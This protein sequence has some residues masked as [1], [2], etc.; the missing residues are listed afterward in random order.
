MLAG[1]DG[2]GARRAD[3]GLD[4]PDALGGKDGVQGRGE[5]GVSVAYEE[6][7]WLGPLGECHAEVPGLLGYPGTGGVGGD[8][9][10]LDEARVVLDENEYVELPE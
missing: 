8:A 10:V 6:L 9:G 4:D 2:V 7:G 5:L 3:G 1:G